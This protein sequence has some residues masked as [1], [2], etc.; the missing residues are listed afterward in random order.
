[1]LEIRVYDRESFV[2]NQTWPT[3]KFNLNIL[4]GEQVI[5]SECI[6]W[7]TSAH[8]NSICQS[9]V[10]A[11]DRLL[12]TRS[13]RWYGLTENIYGSMLLVFLFIFHDIHELLRS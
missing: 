3:L 9:C 11:F 6:I 13:Y 1:M 4:C 8:L 5:E 2:V 10:I 12:E 7:R